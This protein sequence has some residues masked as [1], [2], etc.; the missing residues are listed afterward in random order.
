[1]RITKE[2]FDNYL[3]VQESGMY[4]MFDPK[5]RALT[6]MSMGQWLDIMQNYKKYYKQ[7]KTEEDA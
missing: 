7:F 1:M 4:N 5:A 6:N 2:D 3:F